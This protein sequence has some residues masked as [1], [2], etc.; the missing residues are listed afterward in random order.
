MQPVATTVAR[1]PTARV[2]VRLTPSIPVAKTWADSARLPSVEDRT[3]HV[4]LD[5]YVIRPYARTDP[6]SC[7]HTPGK[8]CVASTAVAA[9]D[10]RWQADLGIRLVFPRTHGGRRRLVG[11][12]RTPSV[13]RTIDRLD[14]SSA[15]HPG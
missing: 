14:R 12:D 2:A 7:H 10:A 5:A 1:S 11:A 15:R 6:E 8:E 9:V 13:A 3:D 4:R